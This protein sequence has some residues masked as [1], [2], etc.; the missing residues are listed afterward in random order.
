MGRLLAVLYGVVC[1]VLFLGTFL[2]AIGFVGNVVVP[3]SIDTGVPG[4]FGE[5]LLINA[6]LLGIFAIQHTVM[7]RP[8]FKK[9]WTKIV[10]RPIERST[11]VLLAS[12]ALV[13]LF[14]QWRPMTDVIWM[15]ENALGRNV[16]WV[17]SALG[18]LTVLVGTFLINH[19]DLF[20][21]RQVYLYM[22]QQPYTES[23]FRTPFLYKIVRHPIMLG[24][25]IAFWSTPDMTVGHLLFAVATT[26]YILIALQFEERDMVR[27]HGQAYE[28][29]RKRV[30]MILPIPK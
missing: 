11:Y 16:L 18:W 4:P 25:L 30:S 15:V 21:L 7:A 17:L 3:K 12:L 19:F 5:A 23:G 24:F 29:Y 1:Y 13:L 9:W 8:G 20:G 14:W 26:G 10:P 2:Y 6:L 28:D 27:F 22:R